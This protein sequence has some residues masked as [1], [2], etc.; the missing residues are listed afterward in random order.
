[1][2]VLFATPEYAPLVK[3][4][5]LGDVSGAL[6]R[7]LRRIG[8]D[9]RV[10]L[11]AY[12]ALREFVAQS[13]DPVAL[14]ALAGMPA[15]RIVHATLPGEVPA[16]LVDCPA[17]YDRGGGPYQDAGGRDWDDN[18][19]RFALLA[20][21]AASSASWPLEWRAEVVHCNDWQT[22]LAPVYFA[23]ASR[24]RAATLMTVHNLAFQGIFPAAAFSGLGLPAET[25]SVGGLE[26]YG[27]VS[28][29]K[30]GLR[31]ADALSTVSPGYAAEIRQPALGFGLHGLLAERSAV[32]SGILNGIDVE[33]WDPARDPWI[34]RNYDARTLET[35]AENKRALQERTG[36]A[37]DRSL[38]LVGVV[39]RLTEQKGIDLVLEAADRILQ[40]PAQ[41]VILGK[42]EILLERALVAL[43]RA[44][45]ERVSVRIGFDEPL[46]HRIEAGAD[47]LLMPSRFEPCGMNQMYSQRYGTIPVVRATGGLV[48][49]VTDCTPATRD[50]GTATGFRFAEARAADLVRALERARAAWRNRDLWRALQRSAM[51]RD[52]GWDAGARMYA[53][54]Y[55][56]IASASQ[57][58]Q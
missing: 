15:A 28:F 50:D 24:P 6:P 38:L 56:R 4:G 16:H 14:P 48:D 21:A 12:P 17:L 43:A 55:E 23:H 39:S 54:L 3:T 8:V 49:S 52:F 5:G 40:L 36:L 57:A 35:K 51:A 25:F 7:A 32:L 2:R 44:H 30:A 46:A 10:L 34:A 22:A 27:K 58:R 18:A 20:R 47:V 42:G 9:V 26:Y 13:R 11:P 1:M 19:I 37:P 41:L 31:Y 33:L 29:L 45:P 53:A